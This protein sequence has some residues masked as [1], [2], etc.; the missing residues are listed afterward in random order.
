MKILTNIAEL[1]AVKQ[2]WQDQT[3]ALVPTMGNLHRGHLALA[4]QA[5]HSAQRVI[6]SIFV[7]PL[8]FGP[9]EDFARYPRTLD[10]DLEQLKNLGVDAVFTPTTE[11]L[12]PPQNAGMTRIDPGPIGD[13]L[14]GQFRPNHFTGV[15]TIV[16]KLFHLVQPDIA[17]F[18]QKDYQQAVIIQQMVQDLNFP[19]KILIAPTVRE[20]DGLA[21]S[22]RN[23]Y[24]NAAERT[25]APSLY[26]T[27]VWVAQQIKPGDKNILALC[28]QAQLRLEQQHFTVDYVTVRIQK[29]LAAPD[30]STPT[31]SLI[32]LAAAF[33]GKTR[34]IDN[35]LV[36]NY[37]T[38]FSKS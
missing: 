23:Q 20:A 21:L 30:A 2:S 6:V 37:A 15:A 26:E 1:S 22:S 4:E 35:V 28:Q 19:L 27:L 34:L 29:T 11:M 8:Q 17:I 24:L 31:E 9:Q 38:N 18:G 12:Y 36:G 32:V 13:I 16:G 33:L 5:Q 7:N 10:A 25:L 3:V 14:C